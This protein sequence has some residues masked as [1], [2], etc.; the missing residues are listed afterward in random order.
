LYYDDEDGKPVEWKT[1]PREVRFLDLKYVEVKEI[2]PSDQ[3]R[4][5][6]KVDDKLS[7]EAEVNFNMWGKKFEDLIYVCKDYREARICLT[8]KINQALKG[9]WFQNVVYHEGIDYI[10]VSALCR[11]NLN[12]SFGKNLAETL[13]GLPLEIDQT[14][15]E[16]KVK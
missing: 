7:L 15:V 11:G 13:K 16:I 3:L 10:K 8:K 14:T 1:L 9:T 6:Y 5:V 2:P 4:G 12:K